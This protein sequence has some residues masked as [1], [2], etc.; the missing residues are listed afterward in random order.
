MSEW[1]ATD[2]SDHHLRQRAVAAAH[3]PHMRYRRSTYE[4]LSSIAGLFARI[5]L[6]ALPPRPGAAMQGKYHWES[7]H[8]TFLRS[9]RLTHLF[10]RHFRTATNIAYTYLYTHY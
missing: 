6:K 7:I 1:G 8:L 3:T 4:W 5:V 9:L 10:S 2:L